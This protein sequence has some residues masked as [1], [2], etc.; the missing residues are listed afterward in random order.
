MISVYWTCLLRHCCWLVMLTNVS[1]L[2]SV[3]VSSGVSHFWGVTSSIHRRYSGTLATWTA[4][5]PTEA[6]S[7][8]ASVVTIV[9]VIPHGTRWAMNNTIVC[10]AIR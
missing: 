5:P 2:Y 8:R 10:M 6:M 4:K 3:S 7:S 1:A 9:A